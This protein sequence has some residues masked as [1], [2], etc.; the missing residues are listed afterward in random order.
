MLKMNA[1][2]Q[3]AEKMSKVAYL[4]CPT[5]IAGDMCLGAL[6]DAGVPLSYLREQLDRLDLSPAFELS[7][8]GVHR[9]GQRATKARVKALDTTHHR[10][11]PEIQSL[12]RAANFPEQVE[13]WSL[14]IFQALAIAEG[15]VH[16]I[17]PES[18][19]FH[20]VGAT[21]A[22][23][24][25]V[26]TCLG[27]DWLGI[28]QI[29]CSALPT[30]GGTVRAAH[31]TLSVPVPAVLEL[32]SQRAVPLYH[33]GINR[34]LVTPTGAAIAVTLAHSFGGPPRMALEQVGLGAGSADLSI[35]NILRLW[36]GADLSEPNTEGQ[37]VDQTATALETIVRLETQVDDMTPQD[38]G[39]VFEC[40]L[41]AGALDVLTI[42]V[43][44]KKSRPGLLIQVF[45]LPEGVST[46]EEL[47]FRETP[48][49]GIR[50]EYVQRRVLARRFQIVQ[51][52]YGPVQIKVGFRGD[53]IDNIQIA[54]NVVPAKPASDKYV[55]H[56][57]P[58]PPAELLLT[59]KVL[60]P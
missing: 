23:V 54:F 36:I 51:T 6:L 38:V 56:M 33:N 57:L 53:R 21:D 22:I 18:V 17:A 20:E 11:L 31:G 28:H 45:C 8:E 1:L 37:W 4:E 29:T 10:H 19:H 26:G 47:L 24:D 42:P 5:G 34:E 16:G 58:R 52:P 44:M 41:E 35:P 48:T 55:H 15:R 27:L 14:G 3:S 59:D 50:R 60:S 40:L 7:L 39:Y 30:G 13:R 46:C 2:N 12:I 32:C 49:L 43:G 9:Q 25:I